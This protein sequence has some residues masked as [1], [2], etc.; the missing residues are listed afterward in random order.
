VSR[1]FA[2]GS[3]RKAPECNV[4]RAVRLVDENSFFEASGS[5]NGLVLDIIVAAKQRPFGVVVV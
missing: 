2:T 1:H 3:Q 5:V 4:R